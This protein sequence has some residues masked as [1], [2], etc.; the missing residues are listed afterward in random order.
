VTAS[1]KTGLDRRNEMAGF[2]VGRRIVPT[3]FFIL[4]GTP[5]V[6]SAQVDWVKD[7]RVAAKQ[8]ESEDKYLYLDI[9]ASW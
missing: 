2:S 4:L 9:S 5:V 3:L 8:A 6:A 1:A 7:F